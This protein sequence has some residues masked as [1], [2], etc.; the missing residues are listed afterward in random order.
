MK[1]DRNSKRADPN[2]ERLTTLGDNRNSKWLA[3]VPKC[4]GARGVVVSHLL[5]MR[6]APGSIPGVSIFLEWCHEVVNAISHL[7]KKT[8]S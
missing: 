1:A 2:P 7:G 8:C 3:I 5:S 4:T 6:E